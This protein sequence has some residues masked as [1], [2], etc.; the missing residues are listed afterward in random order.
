MEENIKLSFHYNMSNN[1]LLSW[2]QLIIVFI[3]LLSD[4]QFLPSK[5]RMTSVPSLH[6]ELPA[7][8][9]ELLAYTKFTNGERAGKNLEPN[10]KTR[11]FRIN[12]K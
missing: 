1:L 5:I 11:R 3:P 2:M 8:Q 12:K 4:N 10:T 9:N 7:T 6:T